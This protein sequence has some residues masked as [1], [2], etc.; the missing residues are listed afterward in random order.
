MKWLDCTN[1]PSDPQA[2]SRIIPFNDVHAD[3]PFYGNRIPTVFY[4]T[5]GLGFMPIAGGSIAERPK[6][7]SI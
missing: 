5:T 6:D 4:A 2:R 3:V 7:W 1:M